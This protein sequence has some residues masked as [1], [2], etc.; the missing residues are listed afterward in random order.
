MMY[1]LHFFHKKDKWH[2]FQ[3]TQFSVWQIKMHNFLSW[4]T[5]DLRNFLSPWEATFSMILCLWTRYAIFIHRDGQPSSWFHVSEWV[6]SFLHRNG[7]VSRRFCVLNKTHNFYWVDICSLQVPYK[8]LKK[9]QIVPTDG[10]CFHYLETT[11][12]W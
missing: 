4:L 10:V 8:K 3:L 9:T 1:L 11:K 12:I 6:A 2:H 7:Q 5:Q